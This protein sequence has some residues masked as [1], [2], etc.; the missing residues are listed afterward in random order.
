MPWR[1]RS[2]EDDA[3]RDQ[4]EHE[5]AEQKPERARSGMSQNQHLPLL[6]P[7]REDRLLP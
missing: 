2:G 3:R 1:N 5:C 6:V 4:K 7:F